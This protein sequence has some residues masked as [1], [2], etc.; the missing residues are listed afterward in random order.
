MA[1]DDPL[2]DLD[3][4]GFVVVVC[5]SLQAAQFT[6][7]RLPSETQENCGLC[8][9]EVLIG[10]FGKHAAAEAVRVAKKPLICCNSCAMRLTKVI[11]SAGGKML[12]VKSAA[13]KES[14]ERSQHARDTLDEMEGKK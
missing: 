2:P 11:H 13:A 14:V 1:T 6:G 10:E 5:R 9:K 8:D 12:A 4:A 7:G 3:L